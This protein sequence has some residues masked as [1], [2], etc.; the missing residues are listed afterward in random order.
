MCAVCGRQALSRAPRRLTSAWACPCTSGRA[1][2]PGFLSHFDCAIVA[3]L[4]FEDM[5]CGKKYLMYALP[6][7]SPFLTSE[8]ALCTEILNGRDKETMICHSPG[9]TGHNVSTVTAPP[10]MLAH[11]HSP[12]RFFPSCPRQELHKSPTTSRLGTLDGSLQSSERPS[13]HPVHHCVDEPSWRRSWNVH[14]PH[15][16]VS[17]RVGH[18]DT[19]RRKPV[20]H[21][22]SLSLPLSACLRYGSGCTEQAMMLAQALKVGHDVVKLLDLVQ[23]DNGDRWEACCSVK[24][25]L[26]PPPPNRRQHTSS[27][28]DPSYPHE[29]TQPRPHPANRTGP[30][31]RATLPPQRGGKG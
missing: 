21:E 22:V 9:D 27:K 10:A 11:Q 31:P 1:R 6:Q 7:L 2:F 19:G 12:T 16:P 20:V 17:R 14:A 8:R 4:G 30:D 24:S 23:V 25:P 13:L 28:M 18:A 3:R 26:I 15:S 5:H 29:N